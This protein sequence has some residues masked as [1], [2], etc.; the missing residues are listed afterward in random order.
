M[1]STSIS[2]FI[3]YRSTSESVDKFLYQLYQ[4]DSSLPTELMRLDSDHLE[5]IARKI[6]SATRL[7][8]Y[9]EYPKFLQ[10]F[11]FNQIEKSKRNSLAIDVCD[12]VTISFFKRWKLEDETRRTIHEKRLGFAAKVCPDLPDHEEMMKMKVLELCELAY[13]RFSCK[14]C[15][16]LC[17]NWHMPILKI[18]LHNEIA[19]RSDI[20]HVFEQAVH[21]Y[22]ECLAQRLYFPHKQLETKWTQSWSE[23]YGYKKSDEI[24]E[25]KHGGGYFFLQDFLEGKHKGYKLENSGLGIQV[26]PIHRNRE[27]F[28]AYR[29]SPSYFDLPAQLTG[30]IAAGQL[31]SANNDY[32]AGLYHDRIEHLK[33]VTVELL[34]FNLKDYLQ[35][36]RMFTFFENDPQ[37]LCR[38][39]YGEDSERCR[40]IADLIKPLFPEKTIRPRRAKTVKQRRSQ[41]P[42]VRVFPWLLLFVLAG[43]VSLIAKHYLSGNR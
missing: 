12:R 32:E 27:R 41:A 23:K 10:N 9:S 40:R 15:L 16:L 34:D 30:R 1:L 18:L 37:E 43:T 28:Y 21:G 6:F 7:S 19:E 11:P 31:H 5:Q 26:A 3:S 8:P 38:E 36:F 4:K 2:D 17:D 20:I 33:D 13:R 24:I 25:V 22:R 35:T 14:E 39:L 29:T 42:I